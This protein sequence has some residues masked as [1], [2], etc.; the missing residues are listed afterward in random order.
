M[1]LSNANS[2]IV[3]I[4]GV[5]KVNADDH[6]LKNADCLIADT[7]CLHCFCKVE[8][9]IYLWKL[10]VMGPFFSTHCFSA[11]KNIADLS[12]PFS[13]NTIFLNILSYWQFSASDP[14]NKTKLCKHKMYTVIWWNCSA[15]MRLLT[16]VQIA[17]IWI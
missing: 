5:S 15:G 10:S 2:E 1:S 9:L 6:T 11:S 12:A 14:P 17:H 3:H 8:Q 7:V 4:H 13:F 16:Q